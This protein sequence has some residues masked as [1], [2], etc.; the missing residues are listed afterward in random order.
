[1]TILIALNMFT[2]WFIA[3]AETLYQRLDEN[4]LG[5]EL[6]CIVTTTDDTITTDM[7]IVKVRPYRKRTRL[8]LW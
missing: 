7:S 1:M 8:S 2:L 3:G 5:D 6:S 4:D